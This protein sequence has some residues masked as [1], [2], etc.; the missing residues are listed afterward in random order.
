MFVTGPAVRQAIVNW[1]EITWADLDR[2]RHQLEQTPFDRPLTDLVRLAETTLDGVARPSEPTAEPVLCP[3][4]RVNGHVIKTIGIAARLDTTTI[5]DVT[6]D[7]LRIELIYPLDATADAFFR[8]AAAT[9]AEAS[10]G[11]GAH[12]PAQGD[13]TGA[14]FTPV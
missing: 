2:L 9:T 12:R 1:P 3:R 11:T 8:R 13:G 6:L 4:F 10:A 7:E 14:A 5:T